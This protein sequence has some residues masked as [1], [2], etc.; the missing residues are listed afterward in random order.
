MTIDPDDPLLA[1]LFAWLWGMALAALW[2]IFG[3]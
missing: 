1:F 2:S 3:S